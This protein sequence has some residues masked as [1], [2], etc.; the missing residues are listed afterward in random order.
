MSRDSSA[1]TASPRV[2]LVVSSSRSIAFPLVAFSLF[3]FSL[4][5]IL[6]VDT[7]TVVSFHSAGKKAEKRWSWRLADPRRFEA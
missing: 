1:T 2:P 6:A 5:S 7:S 4:I 3:P